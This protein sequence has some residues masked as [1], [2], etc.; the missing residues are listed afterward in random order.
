M[1]T[2]P[3]QGLLSPVGE[4][5]HRPVFTVKV[6]QPDNKCTSCRAGLLMV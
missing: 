5:R 4:G 2:L 6:C 1:K 3:G